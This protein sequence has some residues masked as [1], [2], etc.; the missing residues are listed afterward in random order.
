MEAQSRGLSK[1]MGKTSG[2]AEIRHVQGIIRCM[3]GCGMVF[4]A[5]SPLTDLTAMAVYW[6]EKAESSA[7][8]EAVHFLLSIDGDI[9]Q[10]MTAI[11]KALVNILNRISCVLSSDR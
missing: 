8:D 7:E 3:L 2:P 1:T 4:D 9:V 11:E 10:A 6:R 5:L